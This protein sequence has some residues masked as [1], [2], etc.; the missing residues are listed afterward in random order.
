MR[1]TIAETMRARGGLWEALLCVLPGLAGIAHLTRWSTSAGLFRTDT[2]EVLPGS[3]GVHVYIEVKDGS[4]IER[5]LKTLHARCWLA[6]FGWFIV[7][8]GGQ[9]LERSIV[10]RMVFGPERL[11]FEGRPILVPPLDQDPKM[12]QPIPVDGATLDTRVACPDLDLVERSRL[13]ELK[14]K[15]AGPLRGEA[16]K[17]RRQFEERQAQAL[18]KRTGLSLSDAKHQIARQCEGT[19]LPDVVPT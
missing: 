11:V 1:P 12:R 5:F 7:G 10:D 6:G 3:G 4:D 18:A 14:A 17:V 19:L 2:G 8:A 15:A 9:L 13:K 16:T